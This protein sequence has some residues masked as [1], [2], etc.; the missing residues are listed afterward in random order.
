MS[1]RKYERQLK[2]W[3]VIG[4]K[5]LWDNLMRKKS[6]HTR[7]LVTLIL[8]NTKHQ[9]VALLDYVCMLYFCLSSACVYQYIHIHI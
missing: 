4:K 8:K 2:Y 5:S 9:A 1:L 3:F 6:H 7:W